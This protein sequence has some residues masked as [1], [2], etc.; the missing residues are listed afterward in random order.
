MATRYYTEEAYEQIRQTIDQIDTTD[1]C[2]VKDFFTDLF[3]RL[4]QYLEL[5]SV[6]NYQSDMQRWYNIVLDGH[7][8]TM[9]AIDN[10]FTSVAALDFEYRDIMDGALESIVCFRNTVNCL[11]DVI[12][13]KTSIADGKKATDGYLTSGKNSLYSAYDTILTKMESQTFKESFLELIGDGLKLGVGFAS[14]LI[15][16]GSDKYVLKCKKF[17]DTFTATLGDL[18]AAATG[19][20]VGSLFAVGSWFGMDRKN[21]L[22]YRFDQLTEAQD[23]KDRNS[24]SDWM[25]WLAEDM[26]EAL[27]DCPKNSPYYP[28]VNAF[29]T[30]TD[31]IANTSEVVDFVADSY[32]IVSD[33][34]DAGKNIKEWTQGKSYTP[35]EFAEAFDSKKNW[36]IVGYIEGKNGPIIKA[37]GSPAEIISKIISDRTG[38]PLQGWSDPSKYEGNI[39]KTASTIWSYAE[40][41]IPDPVSGQPNYSELPDVAFDKFQDTKLLKDVINYAGDYF[42]IEVK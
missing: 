23:L 18:G 3:L 30:G 33:I 1:I 20:F 41:L 31:V 16:D 11:R 27:D 21:Y 42:V 8:A 34:R 2:P 29:A 25:N 26:D 17:L 7:N 14:L 28:V 24:T 38:I 36:E 6:D 39:W 19:V 10:I 9:N 5:Y 35:E 32:E 22:D 4:G 13:G 12:S 37:K 40:K 15:P